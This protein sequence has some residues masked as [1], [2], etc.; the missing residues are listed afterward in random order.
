MKKFNVTC[1]DNKTGHIIYLSEISY[2]MACNYLHDIFRPFGVRYIGKN[3]NLDVLEI[4][5]RK[6]YYDEIRGLLMGD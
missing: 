6:F 3:N 2:N 4:N 5:N 1:R